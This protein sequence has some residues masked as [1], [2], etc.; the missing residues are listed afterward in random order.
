MQYDFIE[1]FKA[2]S[3]AELVEAFNKEVGNPGWV[4]ARAEYLT[5][6]H[7]EFDERGFD[8]SVIGNEGGLSL[9]REVGL[10]GKKI[11]IVDKA[12]QTL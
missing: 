4:S 3:D 2:M 8:Y 5:V 11:I 7:R 12:D 6:L 9:S 10:E 1:R